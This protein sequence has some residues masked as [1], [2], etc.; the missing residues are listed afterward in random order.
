MLTRVSLPYTGEFSLAASIEFLEGWPPSATQ[1]DAAPTLHWAFY[2]EPGWELTD[3]VVFQEG[4]AVTAQIE[5]GAS[6]GVA[7]AHVSRI[8]GLD[9]DA[10]R[11]TAEHVH[12]SIA[13]ALIADRPGLRPTSFW[14]TYEAAVWAVLSQRISM[15]QASRLK[16]RIAVEHGAESSGFHAFPPPGRLL[17]LETID[18]VA[19]AKMERLHAVAQAAIEGKLEATNLR[20]ISVD[21]ALLQLRSIP[22]IGPFSA[23]LILVRGTGHPDVFPTAERRLHGI[24][25]TVY[26]RPDA[27]PAELAR[28]AEE[29]KPHRSWVSFLFRSSMS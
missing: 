26:E 18:G 12:D 7:S 3:V 4:P 14:S 24:M 11:F 22:G 10:T 8:L 16:Q 27:T 2:A 21:D 17:E 28:I 25:R 19:Q 6:T 20:S 13:A 23:E 29:W 5:T 15:V 1:T 9:V